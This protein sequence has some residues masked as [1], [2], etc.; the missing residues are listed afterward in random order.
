MKSSEIRKKYIEFFK[1]NA[2]KEII[3]FS[4][5][6]DNGR[7]I[8]I[9]KNATRKQ[10]DDQKFGCGLFWFKKNKPTAF[11]PHRPA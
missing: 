5:I 1:K 11:N 3:N 10:S 9:I 6:P 7:E 4:L 2:H 8:G